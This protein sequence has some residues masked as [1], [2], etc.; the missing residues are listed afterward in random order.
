M[1]NIENTEKQK[2][3]NQNW[4]GNKKK[5]EERR[6]KA[7]REEKDEQKELERFQYLLKQVEKQKSNG[8]RG[9]PRQTKDEI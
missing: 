8:M 3:G 6:K 9:I 4:K 5:A 7:E 2:K 1:K